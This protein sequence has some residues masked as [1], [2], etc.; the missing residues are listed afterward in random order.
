QAILDTNGLELYEKIPSTEVY[1]IRPREAGRPEPLEIRVFKLKYA[2][3]SEI[4]NLVSSVLGGGGSNVS[5]YPARNSIVVQGTAKMLS[6]VGGIIQLI[7]LPREQVFIEAKFLELTDSA[8]KQLGIDWQVL[9]G[10]GAGLSG[11]GGNYK[12]DESRADNVNRFSG[13]SG[14]PYEELTAASD[15]VEWIEDPNHP[16]TYQLFDGIDFD[17]R[18][19][20]NP[21]LLRIFGVTPTVESLDSALVNK[22]LTATLNVDDFNLVLAALKDVQ[23]ASVVSNP[24]IIV[25][26]EEQAEIHLG[27]QEPNIRIQRQRGT[28]D[29]PGGSLT[30]E[31]DPSTPYF[32]DG[33]KVVVTPTINTSSNI[34]VIIEPELTSFIGRKKVEQDGYTLIDYPI[35]STK[36]VRTVFSLESGQT[37]AIGGLTRLE[38]KDID[39]KIPVLGDLPVI[40]RFFSYKS[41]S[42]AN[43]ETVIFVTVGLANPANIN[44]ET[45]LPDN[46]VLAMRHQASAKTDRAIHAE[47]LKILETMEAERLQERMGALR[48]SEENRLKKEEK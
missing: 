47:E 13:I 37:A 8:S 15:T 17:A 16:G 2:T 30:V 36:R 48:S 5:T 38:E 19:G 44:M 12:Y 22:A 1:S 7:D 43:S 20:N 4:T 31:L 42:K 25:A 40:G 35:S 6:D 32:E 29:D 18:P 26:N 11:L 45:G 23:G 46:S 3:V 14:K 10:Y 41:T 33:V 21:D 39:R 28:S 27:T 24:K 9:G 34:S